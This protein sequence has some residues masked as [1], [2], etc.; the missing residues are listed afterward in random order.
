MHGRLELFCPSY[1]KREFT[2]VSFGIKFHIN[3]VAKRFE[4]QKQLVHHDNK[5]NSNMLLISAGV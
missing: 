4:I 1:V 5:V 3:N 2:E